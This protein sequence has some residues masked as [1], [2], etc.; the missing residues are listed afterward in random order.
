MGC[1]WPTVAFASD[2]LVLVSS[3]FGLSPGPSTKPVFSQ[4]TDI[5]YLRVCADASNVS[6]YGKGRHMCR[7]PPDV[8]MT[9]HKVSGI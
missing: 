6:G 1:V 3:W 2:V 9:E 7:E 4:Q 8:E 5:A